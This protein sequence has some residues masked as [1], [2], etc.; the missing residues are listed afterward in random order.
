VT[1]SA[2]PAERIADWISGGMS[3]MAS[4]TATWLKPQLSDSSTMM[5]TAAALRGRGAAG[6]PACEDTDMAA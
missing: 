2:A 1:I 4:F 5:A 3:W 6:A